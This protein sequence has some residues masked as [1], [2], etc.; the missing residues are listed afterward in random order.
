M[1]ATAIAA[2]PAPTATAGYE[3]GDVR[4]WFTSTIP[5]DWLEMQGQATAAMH[6]D[7]ITIYGANLPDM[8]DRVPMGASGTKA[9]TT[10]GGSA[11][12]SLTGVELPSHAH[13]GPSHTHTGPSHTHAM[14]VKATAGE[15]GGYG[16]TASVTFED[17]V[18][19]DGA[20]DTTAASGTGATGA[21][22]TGLTSSAGAGTAFSILN[23]YRAIHWLVKVA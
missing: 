9:I 21:D 13:T 10:T 18:R 12:T 2:I 3:I 4:P 20:G 23:P 8:R 16:L 22:G 6:A 19:V 14:N 7:I 5:T 1:V 15:A 11:T 17:R